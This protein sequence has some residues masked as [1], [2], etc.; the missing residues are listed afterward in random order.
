MTQTIEIPEGFELKKVSDTEYKIVKKEKL[1]PKTWKEFC[2]LNPIKPNEYFIDSAG[3][4]SN[5]P[6]ATDINRSRFADSDK[7]L[8]PSGEKA[9]AILALCQLIQLRDCYNNG[10]KSDWKNPFQEKYTIYY[11]TNCPDK[12]TNCTSLRALAFKTRELRDE[13]FDNFKYLIEKLKPLY[14]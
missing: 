7:N 3:N 2:D 4:I 6:I 10:W 5:L 1:L 9:E 12:G 11:N 14:E 13:F 8:L